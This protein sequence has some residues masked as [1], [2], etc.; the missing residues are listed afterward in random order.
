[1]SWPVLVYKERERGGVSG[2]GGRRERG[3][4]SIFVVTKQEVAV[5]CFLAMVR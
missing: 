1:L 2:K 5:T 4:C 3:T